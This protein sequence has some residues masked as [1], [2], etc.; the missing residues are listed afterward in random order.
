MRIAALLLLVAGL[1][2]RAGGTEPGDNQGLAASWSFDGTLDDPAGRDRDTLAPQDGSPRFVAPGEIPGVVGRA[3]ALGV[4]PGDARYLVAPASSDLRLGPSYT[5]EAWIHPIEISTWNRLVL[6]WGGQP[7]Y[8]YHLAIHQGAASLAHGEADARYLFAE[9]GTLAPGQWYHLAAVAQAGEP[10]SQGTLTVYLNGRPVGAA[11]FDGTIGGASDEGLGIGDSAGAPSPDC[12][13]RGYLDDVAIWRRPL[14]TDEIAAHYAS[15]EPVLR[16]LE[17]ARRREELAAR[18][19]LFARFERLGVEE[20]VFAERNPGR[21]PS[22]HYYANFGY[23]C[24]DPNEWLH[25]ADGGRLCRLNLRTG[26]LVPLVDDPGGAVRD[27]VVHYDAGKILFSYRKG[28]T[29]HYHLYEIN[30]DGAGLRQI[31]DGPYDD[32]E[33]CYLPDGGMVFCSSRCHR[34]V[35]CWIAPVAVLFRCDTDGSG[36]RMLSSN[37]VSEN[38]PCVLPDGRVLYTRWEYVNRDPVSFHH[39]WTINPDGTGQQVYFGNQTPGG[40]FIDAQPMPGGGVSFIDAGWHGRNEH[41]GSLMVL[42][43]PAGPN[44]AGAVRPFSTT[45]SELRDPYPLSASDFLVARDRQILWLDDTGQEVVLYTGP[46]MVHEPRPL[47]PR[48]R[49]R[50]IPATT[51]LA[52]ENATL[53]VAD[54]YTGRNMAGVERGAVKKLLV[55]EDL[56]K[57]VNYHG[58]GSTPIGNGG[59]ST[60]KRILGTVPVA[61]D[62]SAHFEVPPSRSLYFALLD[63]QDR[64]IKQMR[65]FVTLQPG[66]RRGCVGCHES[67]VQA[68]AA[69]PSLPIAARR[70]PD[71]IEPVADVPEVLDF[72]RDIQPILDRHCVRCHQ[73]DDR[74]GG[75]V[76]TGDRGPAY[77]LAYYELFVYLQIAD[78]ARGFGHLTGRPTGNDPPYTTYSSASPLMRKIDGSHYDARL[79]A[80]RVRLWIDTAAQYAGTYAAYGTGQIGAWWRNNEPIR[81]MA[82]AWPSTPPARE[83][84]HRRCGACHAGTMPRF[85]TDRVRV[86]EYEDL[87][88]WQRPLSRFSRHRVFNLTR[89]E[90]S[91]VLVAPLSREAGGYA[92]GQP[93]EPKLI[94]DNHAMPPAAFVH[95]VI[96]ASRDDADFQAILAHLQAATARLDQIKRFDMPGFRPRLEYVREM[97][98]YG[99]LPEPFNTAAAPIDPYAT[100]RAYWQSFWHRPGVQRGPP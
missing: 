6:R 36:L 63:S 65:S 95:P 72:P 53:F 5:I 30:T 33:P 64:S 38:T 77:S 11:E 91:L 19:G 80:A 13:F 86:D 94:V 4:Q 45:L 14:S 16:E 35:A 12:R 49:E 15:R 1:A 59:T 60:L 87:E 100:D 17:A 88:S 21:D 62:G 68:A 47:V 70:N 7:N 93:G 40:V 48:P 57:P 44:A 32:I 37:S 42:S 97:K 27:P 50:V 74:Q 76:L 96:F 34:Y 75:V 3:V 46:Q 9:G 26:D 52:A 69:S 43:L 22:G 67:R 99:V 31:T 89:P 66:E 81:E 51:D 8:A 73:P 28:G 84:I 24:T 90:K 79:T 54:V 41:A 83:A 78:T 58:G 20:I 92:E 82:D 98:R 23:A 25:G 61:D 85:V 56:P 71:R 10:P 39:L 55:M 2:Y 18:A 29:H